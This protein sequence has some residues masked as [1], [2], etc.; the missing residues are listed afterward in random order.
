ME[1]VWS[2]LSLQSLWIVSAV[3]LLLV[4]AAH[5][6]LCFTSRMLLPWCPFPQCMCRDMDMV[7]SSR[8]FGER[9]FGFSLCWGG[10]SCWC[11]VGAGWGSLSGEERILPTLADLS[12]TVAHSLPVNAAADC[13]TMVAMG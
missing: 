7:K 1:G 12:A 6:V 11:L 3:F 9:F 10:A 2:C 13:Q 4:I 5:L 8:A